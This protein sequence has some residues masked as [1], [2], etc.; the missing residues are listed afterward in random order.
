MTTSDDRIRQL[1]SEALAAQ[2]DVALQKVLPNLQAAIA[3]HIRIRLIAAQD[4]PR[5]F[6]AD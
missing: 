2:D 4:V 5:V 3:E 6:K 1:C